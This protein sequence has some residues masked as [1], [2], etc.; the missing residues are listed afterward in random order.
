V[1]DAVFFPDGTC[2]E[3]GITGHGRCFFRRAGDVLLPPSGEPVT[4]F[5]DIALPERP[6]RGGGQRPGPRSGSA[7]GSGQATARPE[8][9][10][11]GAH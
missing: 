9:V 5:V 2:T 7:S 8:S 6:R 4:S 11:A 3:Y 1:G 10:P